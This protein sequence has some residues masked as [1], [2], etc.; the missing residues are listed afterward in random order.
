MLALAVPILSQGGTQR[1]EQ[2]PAGRGWTASSLRRSS[3]WR[4]RLPEAVAECPLRYRCRCGRRAPSTSAMICA[5]ADP[6]RGP[7]RSMVTE[8]TCSVRLLSRPVS[9][10][11][12]PV[13]EP[14]TRRRER[15]CWSPGVDDVDCRSGIG[16]DTTVAIY[17]DRSNWWAAY[18]LWVFTLFGHED[19]RLLNGGRA[20]WVAGG[21]EMT[22]DLLK[23]TSMEY[24]VVERIDAPIRAFKDDV[25]AHI[26]QPMV[27]V[28][29]P[30]EFSG[31]AAYARQSAGGSDAWR[32]HP[33]R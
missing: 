17:G 14:V 9:R 33:W 7:M 24:P 31:V 21:R 2:P 32:P 18:A 22:R 6:K 3:S 28:R 25:L 29:S 23:I 20:K 19:V 30:G 10:S 1:A 27:D 11:C 8:R 15:C 5:G 26:G 4:L 12:W 13:E 16:R